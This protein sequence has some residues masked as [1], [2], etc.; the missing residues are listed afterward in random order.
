MLLIQ[1]LLQKNYNKIPQ[2]AHLFTE[3]S[4]IVKGEAHGAGEP[5]VLYL[6]GL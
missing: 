6:S 4:H 2:Y 5:N 1:R 3:L